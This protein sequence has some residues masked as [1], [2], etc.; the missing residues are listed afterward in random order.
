MRGKKQIVAEFHNQYRSSMFRICLGRE[1]KEGGGAEKDRDGD[2]EGWAKT[3][4][5]NA[6]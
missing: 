1:G 6:L 4:Y 2:G 3:R 5:S